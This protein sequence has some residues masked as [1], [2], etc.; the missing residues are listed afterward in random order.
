MSSATSKTT[1]DHD[2]IREWAETRGGRPSRVRGTGDDED[3]GMLR[4]VR[5]DSGERRH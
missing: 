2:E 1:T 3:P 5:R 4:L